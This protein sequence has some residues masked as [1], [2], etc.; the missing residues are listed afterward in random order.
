MK[1][2][3]AWKGEKKKRR[4]MMVLRAIVNKESVGGSAAQ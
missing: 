4:G 2:L 1:K 3:D